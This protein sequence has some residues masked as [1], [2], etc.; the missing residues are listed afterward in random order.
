MVIGLY[1]YWSVQILV[2]AVESHLSSYWS[3]LSTHHNNEMLKHVPLGSCTVS[4][5]VI[6]IQFKKKCFYVSS[7]LRNVFWIVLCI[8][9][10]YKKCMTKVFITD[11]NILFV[12]TYRL[13]LSYLVIRDIKK[14]SKIYNI[15]DT[16]KLRILVV[17][18]LYRIQSLSQF[19]IVT[20]K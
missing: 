9:D 12:V 16:F 2:E 8:F 18:C 3:T 7:V 14:H 10:C 11:S 15:S 19:V 20:Y 13:T 1:K 4:P 6:N 5:Y 17:Y